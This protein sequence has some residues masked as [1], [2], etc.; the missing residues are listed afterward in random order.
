V[1]WRGTAGS[2]PPFTHALT[3]SLTHPLPLPYVSVWCVV[4]TGVLPPVSK[5]T[6]EQ[7]MYH[8]I[9]GY[10]AK[11][12]GGCMRTWGEREGVQ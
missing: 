7:A 1:G 2:P 3:C 11:V 10:T 8:F 12:A 4:P 5:L 9:S 6:H